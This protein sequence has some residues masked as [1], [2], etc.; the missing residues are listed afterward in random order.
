MEPVIRIEGLQKRYGRQLVVDID[1]LSIYAGSVVGLIGPNGA[2]KT[3]ALRCLLGL[4]R[5]QGHL[6]I[7]G[8]D[9]FCQRA[10]LMRDV[11]FIADTAV[12]PDWITAAQLLDY[13][14]RIHPNFNRTKAEV[15]LAQ[16]KIKKHSRV[17]TLSKG[18]KT[19]LHLALVIA[20]EA[21]IL[22]LDEPTLG[23]DILYRQQFY[24]QLLNDYFDETRTIVIT[25]HQVDEIEHILTHLVFIDDGRLALNCAMD[26]IAERYCEVDVAPDLL[27][28]AQAHKPIYSRAQL[29]T[30]TLLY[31]SVDRAQLAQ[32]GVLRTPS[33][34]NLFVAKLS[35]NHS[36]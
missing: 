9:P 10:Q 21:K 13:M 28:A 7:L 32:F 22:F 8:V 1:E 17:K 15:F 3:S 31:E 25:T 27:A 19:Q 35:Q 29:G 18:M 20:I 2:G 14:Q 24:Q 23:L 5:C 11:A 4:A 26:E 16:T 30:T 34:A 12:L 36:G 6:Q 33:I